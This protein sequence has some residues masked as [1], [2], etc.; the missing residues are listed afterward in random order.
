MV[1]ALSACAHN[2]L[3]DI[4]ASQLALDDTRGAH[5]QLGAYAGQVVLVNFFATWCFFCLG[6]IPRLQQLEETR[7]K[8]GLQII[9]VGLDREGVQVLEPFREF[10]HLTYPILVG[11]DRFARD[12]LPFAPVTVLPTSFLVE[13][14]RAGA[15]EVGGRAA[16]QAARR[17]D[18]RRP[19]ALREGQHGGAA[20][21]TEI[22]FL[23]ASDRY[24][25]L[26]PLSF[27]R[28]IFRRHSGWP[29]WPVCAR[30]RPSILAAG[31]VI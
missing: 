19:V 26:A 15:G 30:S 31:G 10:Y 27:R 20:L 11:A 13:T 22:R 25:T 2:P 17:D 16:R 3:A 21:P 6:D 18:R 29:S 4:D 7:A 8:D 14:G 23:Y 9:G 28:A 1:L 24:A 5:I 12:G